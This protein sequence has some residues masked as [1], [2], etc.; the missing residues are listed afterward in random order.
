M[1]VCSRPILVTTRS[2][3]HLGGQELKEDVLSAQQGKS[4]LWIVRSVWTAVGSLTIQTVPDVGLVFAQIVQLGSLIWRC[5]LFQTRKL[6]L[7][8]AFRAPCK[9]SCRKIR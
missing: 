9:I 3:V 8:F 6:V 1:T 7:R 4:P 2:H 5:G